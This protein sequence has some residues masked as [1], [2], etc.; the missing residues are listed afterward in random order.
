M[1]DPGAGKP[2]QSSPFVEAPSPLRA[3]EPIAAEGIDSSLLSLKTRVSV[4]PQLL[5]VTRGV[6]TGHAFGASNVHFVITDKS[7]VVIDTT[8]SVPTARAARVELRKSYSLPVS[9]ILYTHFHH[10]RGARAFHT[11]AACVI[12]QRNLPEELARSERLRA[13]QKHRTA[14][15]D[16]SSSESTNGAPANRGGY[17]P[18]DILFDEQ[19]R[20]VEGGTEVELSHT[21]GETIDHLMVWLPQ[22][23]VLFCGDIFYYSFPMLGSRRLPDRPVLAWA[24]SLDRMRALKPERLV[25]SHGQMLAGAVVIDT[26]LANYAEAIRFVHDETLRGI[27]KGWPLDQIRSRVL[28]P[29]TLRNLPYLQERFGTVAWSIDAIFRHY[30]GPYTFNPTDLDPSPRSI[31]FRAVVETCGETALIDRARQELA[32]GRYQL[33][34]ELADIVLAAGRNAHALALRTEALAGLAEAARSSAARNIY[35]ESV[36]SHAVPERETE[37]AAPAVPLTP[38]ATKRPSLVSSDIKCRDGYV[39]VA[40]LKLHWLDYGGEGE[41]VVA[42]HGLLQ[43]A[44][45]FDAIAPLLVPKFRLVALDLRGRGDSSWG[46]HDAYQWRYYLFDLNGFLDSLGLERFAV[47]G[48]SLGGTLGMIYA[49]GHANRVTRLVMNDTS[50][51]TNR[52]GVVR[53][54]QKHARAPADFANL[55][56]AIDWFLSHREGLHRLSPP[57]LARWVSHYLTTTPTGA[58]CMKCDPII[59]KHALMMQPRVE[60][61]P[62]SHRWVM[63]EQARRLTMPFLLLR[64]ELSDVVPV[65][66]AREMVKE[67]ANARCVEIPGVGHSPT[68]YEPEAQAALAEFFG[69]SVP[70]TE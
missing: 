41:T 26:V 29:S 69:V 42:L 10:I 68:L 16:G 38:P 23:R 25:P 33:A 7:V 57:I 20:F 59:I 37:S 24:E 67:M 6:F 30:V 58:L 9:H 3:R 13:Y 51:N 52:A 14:Q 48:T 8:E 56:Q 45:A 4:T 18:P 5:P 2:A 53:A 35:R 54:C 65:E 66:S 47:L 31:L 61:V 62:W 28:L 12:A 55:E 63:W 19:H 32:R 17:V 46:P 49:M 22:T 34:L 60:G 64:G 27:D 15:L 50:L 40:G 1:P 43:N 70:A 36:T 39:T 21:R 11:P 44:R